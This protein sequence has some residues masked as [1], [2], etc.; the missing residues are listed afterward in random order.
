MPQ[1]NNP[2]PFLEWKLEMLLEM[3][4]LMEQLRDS[5]N[6]LFLVGKFIKESLVMGLKSS[7][8]DEAQQKKHPKWPIW[9]PPTQ[10]I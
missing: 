6:L 1:H 4:I 10:K 7:H 2:N 5:N 8:A 3:V 9:I